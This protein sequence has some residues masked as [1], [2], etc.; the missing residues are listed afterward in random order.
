MF[1]CTFY[2]KSVDLVVSVCCTIFN[3]YFDFRV[4]FHNEEKNYQKMDMYFNKNGTTYSFFNVVGDKTV[5]LICS[6]DGLQLVEELELVPMKEKTC[7]NDF[8]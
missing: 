1:Y 4:H 5:C 3:T 6:N 2:L 8:F 7:A